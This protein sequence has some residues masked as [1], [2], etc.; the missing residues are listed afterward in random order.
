MLLEQKTL[1]THGYNPNTLSKGSNKP[2]IV[3]CDYCG[4]ECAITTKVRTKCNLVINKD[5]CNKCKYIKR[6]E[7]C[8]AKYGVTNPGATKEVIQKI[9]DVNL[10]KHGVVS[11]FES[12]EFKEKSNTTKMDKYGTTN[13]MSVPEIHQRQ[14]DAIFNKY[15]VENISQAS[16]NREK[17]NQTCLDKYGTK[18]FLSSDYARDSI[19]ETNLDK[20]GVENQFQREECKRQTRE[21]NLE[22]LGV[23]YPMQSQEVRDRSKETNLERYGFEYASMSQGVKDKKCDTSMSKYGH[24]Y[25]ASSDVVK[26]KIRETAIKN[27]TIKIHNGQ[28][29]R[30]LAEENSIAYTTFVA[31]VREYG[32]DAALVMESK[33]NGLEEI[34][35]IILDKNGVNYKQNATLN[36][37]KTDFLIED[38]KLVLELDGLYWH[39]DAN[40]KMIDKKYHVKKRQ[41]YKSVGY[42]S[43]FFRE[44]E[45]HN[46]LEIVESIIMN[47]IKKN[48][49]VFARKCYIV[50]VDKT[51]AKTFFK[52]NHLMGTGR[53]VV[54]GLMYQNKLVSAIQIKKVK[55]EDYEVSR[56]CHAKNT[57]VTGAFS[58]L[59]KFAESEIKMKTLTTFIDLRYGSGG[60]L[61]NFGF[62]YI[63]THLSF[64]WAGRRETFHR[65]KFP[66]STGYDEGLN[67]IW[68]CG[69]SK[70][71]KTY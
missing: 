9:K 4:I 52:E 50:E 22:N 54:Y 42:R 25:P 28:T 66:R 11:Y 30:Q 31:N 34:I 63:K 26:S 21:T 19:V 62:T 27:G 47:Y 15:G 65:M 12:K 36:G 68:D 57:S 70:F 37:R 53:G 43:M 7:V 64:K 18:E 5:C 40:V 46:K 41:D 32:F 58:R 51:I 20:Y 39:S 48:N 1:E 45:V 17:V 49:K 2:I 61:P 69:Q 35:R 56:F 59:L 3:S 6:D 71:V 24:Q 38:S 16:G 55:D 23:E 10:A 44:D 8:I 13:I 29:M 14:K 67:R 33:K 60:Y